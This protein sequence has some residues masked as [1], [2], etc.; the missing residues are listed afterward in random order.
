MLCGVNCTA[1]VAQTPACIQWYIVDVGLALMLCRSIKW[2][3]YA[4]K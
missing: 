4:L 3:T 2:A 1:T